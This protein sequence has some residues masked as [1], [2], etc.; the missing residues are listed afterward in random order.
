MSL[1]PDPVQCVL[2][3]R[4]QNHLSC[5][6]RPSAVSSPAPYLRQSSPGV[7][8]GGPFTAVL[9]RPCGLLCST[10]LSLEKMV[11]HFSPVV[12]KA[13]INHFEPLLPFSPSRPCQFV[14]NLP[15]DL[16]FWGRWKGS[17][18][19]PYQSGILERLIVFI[20]HLLCKALYPRMW[21]ILRSLRHWPSCLHLQMVEKV[22]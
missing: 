16:I 19:E 15:W 9:A 12:Q 2:S 3:P 6:P 22:A 11:F 5:Q 7:N 10:D 13:K 14:L 17:F 21:D 4:L 18:H 20:E 1:C 8:P